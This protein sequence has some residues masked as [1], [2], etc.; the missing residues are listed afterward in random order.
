MSALLDWSN[1]AIKI[2][3]EWEGQITNW[4]IKGELF[5]NP[6]REPMS[7]AVLELCRAFFETHWDARNNF[8]IS[9]MLGIGSAMIMHE[10]STELL[11]YMQSICTPHEFNL[12]REYMNRPSNRWGE[13]LTETAKIAAGIAVIYTGVNALALV[14]APAAG[15]LAGS[16]GL[17]SGGTGAAV[18]TIGLEAGA[19]AGIIGGAGILE[20]TL[21]AST[22]AAAGLVAT[23]ANTPG[24]LSIIAE[25]AEQGIAIIQP[26][27]TARVT[28]ELSNLVNPKKED[29]TAVSLQPIQESNFIK[30]NKEPLVLGLIA[31]SLIIAWELFA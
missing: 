21:A 5:Y 22:L 1:K 4:P 15:T 16:T 2:R 7:V 18:G 10:R 20:G 19:S 23:Q 8:D 29:S 9:Q 14:S 31:G 26:I 12:W 3:S 13:F 6:E 30:Q 11:N 24:A 25:I 27:A 17:L 28:Q